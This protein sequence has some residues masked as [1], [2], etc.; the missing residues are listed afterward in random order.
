MLCN[1][2]IGYTPTYEGPARACTRLSPTPTA[3]SGG[4]KKDISSKFLDP[5]LPTRNLI[6]DSFHSSSAEML[7]TSHTI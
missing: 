5:A 3:R 7:W 6:F 1:G 4:D 2:P